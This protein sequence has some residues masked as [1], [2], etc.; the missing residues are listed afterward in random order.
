MT[1]WICDICGKQIADD[2]V[3]AKPGKRVWQANCVLAPIF[4]AGRVK[5]ERYMKLIMCGHC[6]EDLVHQIHELIQNA[7]TYYKE[8]QV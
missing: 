8:Y 1:K 6:K 3:V 5:E 4:N 2:G 7:T